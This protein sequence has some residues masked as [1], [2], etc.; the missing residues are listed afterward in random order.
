MLNKIIMGSNAHSVALLVFHIIIVGF[1]RLNTFSSQF[2][3]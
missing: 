3:S 1:N 2:S